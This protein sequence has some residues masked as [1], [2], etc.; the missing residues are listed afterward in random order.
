MQNPKKKQQPKET[1][2]LRYPLISK[3]QKFFY[4]LLLPVGSFFS[5]YLP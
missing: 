4:K 1:H 3:Q 5:G 2:F